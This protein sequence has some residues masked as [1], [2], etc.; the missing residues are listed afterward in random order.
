MWLFQF[1][2]K[3][4][5]NYKFPFDDMCLYQIMGFNVEKMYLHYG[6]CR[7]QRGVKIKNEIYK[8]QKMKQR[9]IKKI[10]CKKINLKYEMKNILHPLWSAPTIGGNWKKQKKQIP[11]NKN[12]LIIYDEKYL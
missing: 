3:F 11:T 9:K 7:L 10:I 6:Q 2:Y 12:T 8:I 5:F 1:T 4:K